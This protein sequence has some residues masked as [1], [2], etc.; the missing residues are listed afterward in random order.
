MNIGIDI[1]ALAPSKRSGVGNYIFHAVQHILQADHENNYYLF[2]AGRRKKLKLPGEL[3]AD[4]IQHIHKSIS[5]KLLNLR[6]LFGLGPNLDSFFPVKLDCL[7]LPNIN[8]IKID[9]KLPLMLTI[10]DLSFL[11]SKHFYSL[12]RKWWHKLVNVKQLINQANKIIAVSHN[13]KRDIVRF[14]T[15]AENKIEVIYPGASVM[16]MDKDRAKA[17]IAPY[18]IKEHYWLYLGTLEPRKNIEGIIKAFDRYHKEYPQAELVLVGNKGW[19]YQKLLSNVRKRSYIK[20]LGFVDS[21]TKDAL[22]FLSQG[23]LWPSFYEGFGF[24]PLE[25]TFHQVP[26]ITSYKTSLPEIMKNQALYVDPYNVS[27]IYQL[28]KN[29][30]EDKNFRQQICDN[31]KDFVVPVWPKQVTK[32][33][34]LFKQCE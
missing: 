26:V 10:H 21:P 25:A 17:L 15:I 27:E 6:F 33:I 16:P 30:T 23:L 14:F 24:P 29:L 4:N 3:K 2:S 8:F 20:Y 18:K 19:I 12:K 34:N 13:T 5:N 7:W 31:S 1:R 9:K 22:Y 32:I 28:L 11:H